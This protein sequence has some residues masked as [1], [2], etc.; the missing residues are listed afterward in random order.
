[1]SDKVDLRVD[2]CS[3]EA[4]K[5]AV[6]KWH[7]S[8]QTPNQK[9]AKLG[10]WERGKFIGCVLF[11][12]SAN[13][14]IGTPYGLKQAEVCELVRVALSRHESNVS[15]I[16]SVSIKKLK[17]SQKGLRLI[18]SYADP[19]H[20]H[21]G[22]I[23][24]AGN[25]VYAGHTDAADEYIVNGIRMHGRALRSTRSTHKMGG[26][27]ADNVMEWAKKIIDPNI[28]KVTGS[29][30]HRYL[31]PL[32]RAMRKQIAPLAQPYPKRVSCGLGVESD[33]VG[34]QPT[35][36]GATPAARSEV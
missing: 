26:V 10:V 19:E 1:M 13:K 20:K 35:G 29:V 28:K 11:G 31:Y 14:N 5:Y 23:Y 18:V 21:V 8:G 25:W 16:V 3:Y 17:Q 27:L 12:S 36:A 34:D 9:L 32:D 15:Q 24:Q 22:T 33:T 6:E 30:K 2:W 4:A 7:Y